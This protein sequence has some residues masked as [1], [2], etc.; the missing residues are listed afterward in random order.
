MTYGA[1]YGHIYGPLEIPIEGFPPIAS[2]ALF[3]DGEP[4]DTP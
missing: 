1:I 4:G 2:D 3:I